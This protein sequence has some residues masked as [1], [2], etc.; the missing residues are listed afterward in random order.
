MNATT[1]LDLYDPTESWGVSAAD[2]T[3][4]TEVDLLRAEVA[5]LTAFL[6]GMAF[7]PDWKR[8]PRP[9]PSS[10]WSETVGGIDESA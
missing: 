5:D 8:E 9:S 3:A 10:S 2:L 1:T 6:Y 4:M 7:G